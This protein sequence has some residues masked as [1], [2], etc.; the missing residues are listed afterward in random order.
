MVKLVPSSEDVRVYEFAVMYPPDLAQNVENELLKEIDAIFAD[1]KAK[2]LFK[3][4]WS[5][6][7]LAY[8]IKGY[9]EAKFCIYY[10]EMDPAKMREV[11]GAIRLLKNVMRHLIVIPPKGYEAVNYEEKYKNWLE[12][13]ETIKERR[14]R[15]RDEK[16]KQNVID[17][18]KRE[19]RRTAEKAKAAPKRAAIKLDQLSEELDKLISD[20]DLKS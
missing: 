10:M 18:A 15:E 14:T 8:K 7:G 17:K 4:P 13:R 9:L 11:D 12:N 6:R 1:A 3:D 2:L 5:K 19:T 20:E 16:V